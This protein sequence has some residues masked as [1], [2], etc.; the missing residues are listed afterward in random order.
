VDHVKSA[1]NHTGLIET[2]GLHV[3]HPLACQQ[4]G[5]SRKFTD[6]PHIVV[7]HNRFYLSEISLLPLVKVSVLNTSRSNKTSI[8]AGSRLKSRHVIII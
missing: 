5:T 4:V 6:V 1:A 7:T 2:V 8:L 3:A